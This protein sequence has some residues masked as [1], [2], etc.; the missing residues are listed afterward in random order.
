MSGT[1]EHGPLAWL[2]H[3]FVRNVALGVIVVGFAIFAGMQIASPDKRVI[4][5]L[6]ALILVFFAFR[7][8]S[9]SAL[10][11][12]TL[13]LPFPKATSYGN[14]NVTFVLLIF[15]VW[16][17]RVTT[18]RIEPPRKIPALVPVGLLV[19]S[20]LI[21][22]YNVEAAHIAV[23]WSKFLAFLSYL[24]LAYMVVNVVRTEADVRKLLTMQLVSCMLV[25]LFGIYELTHPG[26]V[27]IP[28]WI[29]FTDTL[30]EGTRIG[31]T[32]LD[33]ELFGEYCA[34]NVILQIFLFTR[35]T[36]KSR[37]FTLALCLALTIFCL[38]AT[39]TRGAL[40]TMFVGAVYLTWLSRKRIS[41]QQL[42]VGVAAA[43]AILVTGDAVVGGL[44]HSGSVLTRLEGTQFV[45]G[46][47]DSRVGAWTY[48]TKYIAEHP[49]IGHGTYYSIEKGLETRWWPHNLYLYYASIVGI[50]GL[51]CF[52]WFLW[53]LWKV[54][55]P[56]AASLG[57]GSYLQGARLCFRVMLVMFMADQTKIEYLR[58]ERYSFFVWFFFG[59]VVA[60]ATAAKNEWTLAGRAE[61]I[62]ETP[63]RPTAPRLAVAGRAAVSGGR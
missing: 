3:P 33:Y 63:R 55:T 17:Y 49:I 11:I 12:A 46:V 42:V 37:K 1:T 60:V 14:T 34:L 19:V 35:A 57:S 23:A 59:L 31:S 54:S 5:V 20:Y 22:F 38:F 27:L 58:N 62:A 8:D 9:V 41:F 43:L 51:S 53:E 30:R 26:T 29:E 52:L 24:F 7:I 45:G 47:P 36:S 25:C 44:G 4:Q 40:L 32:F 61:E 39:V 56:R 6:A 2:G 18:K 48:A 50:L 10:A 21:S 15:I 16:L 28:G 13:F